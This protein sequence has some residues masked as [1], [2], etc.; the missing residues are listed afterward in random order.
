MASEK[1]I[2]FSACDVNKISRSSGEFCR[3]KH[4]INYSVSYQIHLLSLLYNLYIFKS[5]NFG[6]DVYDL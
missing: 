2:K 3:T 1:S 5:C 4:F 6:T